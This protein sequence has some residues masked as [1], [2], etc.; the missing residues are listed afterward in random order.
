MTKIFLISSTLISFAFLHS[1]GQ[2]TIPN[3]GFEQW[4]TP[5]NPTHWES[6]N[7]MLPPGTINCYQTTNSFEGEYALQLKTIDLSGTPV[8]GV[9]TLGT[10]DYYIS[11][12]GVPFSERPVALK[13]YLRHPSSGDEI[14][15]GI[16]FFKNG[17]MIGGG[18]FTTSDSIPEFTEFIVPLDYTSNE[19]PDTLNIT[20]LTDPY[21]MGSSLLVDALEFE[22]ET[23]GVSFLNENNQ[24][25]RCFPNP[26]NGIVNIEFPEYSDYTIKV[27]NLNGEVLIKK[28]IHSDICPLNLEALNPG[29]YIIRTDGNNIIYSDKVIIR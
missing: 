24:E 7:I 9:V 14:L 21:V 12:G 26:S 16:E 29:M 13:G 22:F 17:N 20:I 2:D 11:Y 3:H 15:I 28:E 19:Y 5:I 27:L 8:P 4:I 6:T 1:Y 23:T 18:L 10:I 25:I